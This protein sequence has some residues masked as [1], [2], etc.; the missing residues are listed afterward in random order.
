[1]TARSGEQRRLASLEGLDLEGLQVQPPLQVVDFS[2]SCA[3]TLALVGFCL[4][5]A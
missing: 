2:S 1:M 3:P 4:I 5:F